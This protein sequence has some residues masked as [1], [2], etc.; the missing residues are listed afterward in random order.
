MTA[1]L[2]A[3]AIVRRGDHVLVAERPLSSASYPGHWEFPGG[4]LEPGESVAEAAVRELAEELGVVVR[5]SALHSCGVFAAPG[6]TIVLS[7]VE[8]ELDDGEEPAPLL[9][10]RLAWTRP[11]DLAHLRMPPAD[12]PILAA[13]LGDAAGEPP[14]RSWAD[15]RAGLWRCRTGPSY[16]ELDT[17]S[18]PAG[19]RLDD[20][21]GALLL[22][23]RDAGLR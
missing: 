13:L 21:G 2:V 11:E 7:A 22:R 16:L 23:R 19:Y 18:P 15:S 1:L 9:G 6:R 20:L 12:A 10:Q 17:S 5:A 14:S 3:A 8:A 4:K